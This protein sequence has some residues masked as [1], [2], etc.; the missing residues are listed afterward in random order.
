MSSVNV[1]LNPIAVNSLR[2][3]LPPHAPLPSAVQTLAFWRD[4][5]LYLRLC[6]RQ[7][8]PRFTITPTGKPPLVFTSDP[9]DIRSIVRAPA[10]ILHPGAGGAVIAPLVGRGSFMISEGERHLAGRRAV[11]PGFHRQRVG[12]HAEMVRDIAVREIASWPLDTPSALHPRLR[13][14]TLRV[15]LRMIFDRDDSLLHELHAKLLMM[16]AVTGSLVLQEPRL[17]RLP[18]WRRAW[19]TFVAARSDVER[20]L[21]QLIEDGKRTSA[22]DRSLLAMLLATQDLDRGAPS[23]PQL[24]ETL[25]SV[26]LAGHETTASQLAWAFQLLAHNPTT[27]E[28]LLDDLDCG[29]ERYLTA[30]VYEVLR[31]RPVFLFTIPRAVVQ[32]FALAGTTYHPPVHLVGCVHLMHHEPAL[33][34]APDTFSPERFLDNDPA[35]DTW[36]PWGGGRKRCPGHHLA[37]LEIRTILQTVLPQLEVRPATNRVE[38]GRWRSVIVTP[39][40]GCCVTLRKRTAR[41]GHG[42]FQRRRS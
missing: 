3:S 32:P 31:H 35:P 15:I 29:G 40:Q 34:E 8:G 11:L 28:H 26:I 30:V 39:G 12:E 19:G 42:G 6:R 27:T 41:A 24:R 16:F 2:D 10:D 37:M 23:T 13:A 22:A 14:L 21:V 18:R 17:R 4:P 36:L 25:M 5:H 38:T 33:Y 20:L 9:S 1:S 7:Y